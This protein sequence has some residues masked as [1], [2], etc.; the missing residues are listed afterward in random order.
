M[1]YII[2]GLETWGTKIVIISVNG[3]ILNEFL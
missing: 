2:N 3:F 1:L